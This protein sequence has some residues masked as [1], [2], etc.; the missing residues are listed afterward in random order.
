MQRYSRDIDTFI[1]KRALELA[2]SGK[3][4]SEIAGI[5]S[6]ETREE[7]T[8]STV[9]GRLYRTKGATIQ[10]KQI[11]DMPYF[12]KYREFY[13]LDNS[14]P[15]KLEYSFSSGP[16]KILNLN[17]IH[18]PF[19]HERAF[20]QAVETDRSADV[21]VLSE[22]MD[23]YSKTSFT[24][25]RNVP[26]E[27]EIEHTIRIYE[28]LSE[29]FPV[30]YV[31]GSTH[32]ARVIRTITSRIGT[33]LLFLT[34]TN[35]PKFLARPFPNVIPIDAVFFVINDVLFSHF[36]AYSNTKPLG[37]VDKIRD[38]LY[39]W[40]EAL[41]IPSVRV[42][43]HGHTHHSGIYNYVNT[44]IVETGCLENIT[45]FIVDTMPSMPWVLGWGVVE[46]LDGKT[47]LNKTRVR[48]YDAGRTAIQD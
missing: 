21:V 22:V 8:R 3:S 43:M 45:D 13:N 16:V 25:K 24:K 44:Q 20:M 10:E 14:Y 38:W 15:D 36:N 18:V 35:V 33:D 31:L 4:E 1:T 29:N 12:N 48:I 28:F 34:E 27:L 41:G 42:I 19:Q 17:D 9:H 23:M 11:P 37:G 7:I 40:K 32:D 26:L 46:Q 39:N 30:T 5:I 47:D 2:S 6:L